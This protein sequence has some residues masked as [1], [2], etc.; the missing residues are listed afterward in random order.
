MAKSHKKQ[1]SASRSGE[2]HT[3]VVKLKDLVNGQNSMDDLGS[4]ALTGKVSYSIGKALKKARA[5]VETYRESS[6]KLLKKLG[7]VPSDRGGFELDKKSANWEK[8]WKTMDEHHISAL[9]ADVELTGVI[10]VTL[11]ELMK[12]LP[13]ADVKCPKCDLVMEY[14]DEDEAEKSIEPNILA[15]LDWLITEE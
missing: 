12:A 13:L 7:A 4:R 15:D 9:E 10:T 1:G 14:T 8:A 3:I 11:D 5:E 6:A 2:Q